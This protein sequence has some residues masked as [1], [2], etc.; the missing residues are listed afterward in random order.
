MIKVVKIFIIFFVLAP[1]FFLSG[2]VFSEEGEV[3]VPEVSEVTSGLTQ[4][5]KFPGSTIQGLFGK[6]LKYVLGV[7]GGVTLIMFIYSGLLWMFSGGNAERKKKS[8]Q[9]MMWTGIGVTVL[10]SSYAIIRFVLEAFGA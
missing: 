5:N 4:L 3:G 8:L 1:V 7:L 6:A 9:T 10:L 2:P